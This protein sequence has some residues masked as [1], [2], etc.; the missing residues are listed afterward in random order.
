MDIT[1]ACMTVRECQSAFPAGNQPTVVPFEL[2]LAVQELKRYLEA[3]R[4]GSSIHELEIDEQLLFTRT[5]VN[6][7]MPFVL[8]AE[9]HLAAMAC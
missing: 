9:R 4:T 6:Y 7:V 3:Q 5:G 2:D 8:S 1:E